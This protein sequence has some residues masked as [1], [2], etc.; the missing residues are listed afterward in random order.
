MPRLNIAA[1][2]LASLLAFT[3]PQGATIYVDRESI[4]TV[5]PG[6]GYCKPDMTRLNLGTDSQCVGE[7]VEEVVKA[8]KADGEEAE[9]EASDPRC[10]TPARYKAM[11]EGVDCSK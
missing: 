1:P 6:D 4:V 11:A 3:N 8:I 9:D 10:A 5:A 7:T 2:I